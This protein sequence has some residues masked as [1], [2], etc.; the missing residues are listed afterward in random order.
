MIDSNSPLKRLVNRLEEVKKK[1]SVPH[2]SLI[3][4]NC[5]VVLDCNYNKQR[6]RTV[7][8]IFDEVARLC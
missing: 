1:Y 6:K 7:A 8:K 3:G 5:V 2:P 4:K